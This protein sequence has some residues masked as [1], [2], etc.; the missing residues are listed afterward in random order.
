MYNDIARTASERVGIQLTQSEDAWLASA[1]PVDLEA[2]DLY[3][4]GRYQFTKQTKEGAEKAIEYFQQAIEIDPDYAQ[5]H[6]GLVNGYLSLWYFRGMSLEE[7]RSRVNPLLRKVFEIDDTLP[8]VHFLV[9][10]IKHYF[11]WD[12]E[13]AEI[14]YKRTIA[15]DPSFLTAH[16]HYAWLLTAMGR[17]EEAITEAK[18]A[19]ELDPFSLMSNNA[20]AQMHTF[21]GQYDKAIEHYRQ[22]IEMEPND[23]RLH[24][25]LAQPYECMGRYE[26]AIRARQKAM[27][28]FERSAEKVAALVAEL[29]SAY[30]ESGPEGYWMWVLKRL[31]GNYR[32]LSRCHCLLLCT[33]RR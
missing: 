25:L 3:L 19:L 23:S 26:D 14:E 6:A 13:G 33:A 32:P 21:S 29:D 8:E 4:R 1:R 20:F 16:I 10:A 5:A 31:E 12:W 27:T 28:L 11:D 30:S 7:A 17:S 24:K 22:M 2:H 18:R 15:L 9:A